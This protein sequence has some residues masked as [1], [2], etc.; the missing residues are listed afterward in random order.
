MLDLG[1]SQSSKVFLM[2]SLRYVNPFAPDGTQVAYSKKYLQ[3]I[4]N[5]F[6]A[7]RQIQALVFEQVS[8]I[9]SS[10]DGPSWFGQQW[11]YYHEA[12]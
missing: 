3:L 7:L 10:D 2:V 1:P 5:E 11:R 4:G 6:V 8:L 9:I 12:L